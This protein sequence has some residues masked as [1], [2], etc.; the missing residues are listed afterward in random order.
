M[1]ESV[2]KG[3]QEQKKT[4]QNYLFELQKFLDIANNI[5]DEDFRYRIICQM[6]KVDETLTKVL[7]EYFEK[8]QV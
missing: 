6:L 5:A 7:E 3:I 1:K 2:N 8:E 4:N